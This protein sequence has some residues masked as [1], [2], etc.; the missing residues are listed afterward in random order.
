LVGSV[1]KDQQT[2][3]PAGRSLADYAHELLAT[4]H[5]L[6]VVFKHN[7][8]FLKACFGGR[9]LGIYTPYLDAT[10]FLK[11]KLLGALR[12]HLDHAYSEVAGAV[13]LYDDPA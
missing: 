6:A 3:L 7:I 12:R 9:T 13:V 8:A 1:A 11:V 4:L 5:P 10:R 2:H